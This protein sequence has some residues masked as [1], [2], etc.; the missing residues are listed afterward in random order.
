MSPAKKA[1]KKAPA[2]K[3]PAKKAAAK[4]A[5]AKK[6]PAE[7]GPGQEGG[8]Q[9]EGAGEEGRRPRRLRPRRL[10]PRE[11]GG[12]EGAGQEGSRSEGS[13]QAQGP[14]SK[15]AA[16][17]KE[18]ETPTLTGRITQ[19]RGPQGPLVCASV[20]DAHEDRASGSD[21]STTSPPSTRRSTRSWRRSPSRAGHVPRRRRDG[22]SA[23]RSATS[24]FFDRHAMLAL[25]DPDGFH[26][27]EALRS[28]P[29]CPDDGDRPVGRAGPGPASRASSCE[30]GA[31]AAQ[32]SSIA[33]CPHARSQGPRAV[34]RP[35]DERPLVHHGAADGDV[36]PRPGRR[37]RPRRGPPADRAAAPRRP[38]RRAA[39]GRSAT[40][41]T[42]RGPSGD[43]ARRARG[44]DGATWTWGPRIADR[45]RTR[46]ALDFCLVVTQRR[47]RGRHRLVVEG[48]LA[49]DWIEIA[50]AFAGPPGDRPAAGPVHSRS[51]S[52]NDSAEATPTAPAVL[53]QTLPHARAERVELS[54]S[55]VRSRASSTR[56]GSRGPRARPA[57]ARANAVTS[58]TWFGS[59]ASHS[60]SASGGGGHALL[61]EEVRVARGDDAVARQAARRGG[62]RGGG[63]SASTGRG[64]ARRRAAARGYQRA[65]SARSRRPE[66]SSPSI[67][68][69]EHDLAAWRRAPSAAARCSS[70]RRATSADGVGRDVPRALRPVGAHEVVDDA[71]GRRPLGERAPG[72]E[73]DVV[74]V[75]A[76]GQRRLTARAGRDLGRRPE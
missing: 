40:P 59:S 30:H 65:T 51:M 16:C 4:K 60:S 43:G 69:E 41:R 71:A 76:D 11:G 63:G 49:A 12:Q 27:V 26:A 73:L 18:V 50:Q 22:P 37:R 68:A 10:R 6:A 67:H 57:C 2:K 35:G 39:P 31:R 75:G 74:G 5:P 55:S 48:P 61:G 7:E 25:T 54:S 53:G 14:G 46:R 23:T 70:W 32:R 52:V 34:V 28:G 9:E 64:R 72:T 15:E 13:G 3:A 21:L 33:A 1:A 36:G 47:H 58:S 56:T 20:A 8:R 42:A 24:R 45:C 66:S 29:R 17:S 44:P 62:G 19:S 38:H